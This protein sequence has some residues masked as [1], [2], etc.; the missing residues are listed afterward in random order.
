MMTYD[1][2][3]LPRLRLD[4][5]GAMFQFVKRNVLSPSDARDVHLRLGATIHNVQPT[6]I[7]RLLRL[8]RR[9]FQIRLERVTGGQVSRVHEE[10]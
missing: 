3:V 5:V 1:S 7:H 8:A 6:F 9:Q 4:F 2:Y 10:S